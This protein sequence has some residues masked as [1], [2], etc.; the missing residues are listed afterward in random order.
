MG[1]VTMASREKKSPAPQ[2]VLSTEELISIFKEML[3]DNPSSLIFLPLA[4]AYRRQGRFQ[5]AIQICQAGLNKF[6]AYHSARV[7]LAMAYYENMMVAEAKEEFLQIIE[8][9][10]E[11]LLARRMLALI[12]LKEGQIKEALEHFEYVIA[13]NP[14]DKGLKTQVEELRRTSGIEITSD[15]QEKEVSNITIV[16]HHGVQSRSDDRSASE[17]Q[18]DERI[19]SSLAFTQNPGQTSEEMDNIV[20]KVEQTLKYWLDNIERAK[21]LD[22]EKTTRTSH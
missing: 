19:A 15:S 18:P 20:K 4:E 16:P 2:P 13:L 12:F 21:K 14:Y 6:P 17:K 8:A 5:D 9:L 3:S 1:F 22:S 7:S 11:N 10:P